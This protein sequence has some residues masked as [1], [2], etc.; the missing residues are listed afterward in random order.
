MSGVLYNPLNGRLTAGSGSVPCG[1]SARS[2]S[3]A[4]SYE[5][6]KPEDGSNHWSCT[7]NNRNNARNVNFN[8]GNAN[9]NNKYNGNVVRAVA[10]LRGYDVPEDFIASVWE[11]YHDCIRG[12]RR[13]EQAVEYM[14]VAAEDIPRL[15]E[16]LWSGTYKPG[17]STCF[18]V[19]YP[20]LREVFAAHFRDRIV[21]HWICLRLEPLFEDR[22]ISQGNVSF[23]CRKGFGTDKAVE[24]VAEGMRTVSDNYHT[25]AWVFKGDLVG[26]F[27]S[28][29]KDRLW[30]RLERFILR[31]QKK[32][33]RGLMSRISPYH[34]DTMYYPI[35]LR[36]AK[37]VVM[38]RPERDCVLNSPPEWWLN[39]APNKS[40]FTMDTGMP[41]GNLTTQLFANFYMSFFVAYV[42]WLFRH[43][44]YCFAQFVD[45]F[46]IICDDQRF[47]INAIPKIEAFLRDVLGLTLH[48]EKRYF[49]PVSHGVLFVGAFIKPGRLYLSNRTVGRMKERCH[50]FQKMLV[51]GEYDESNLQH[52][53]CTLNS[54]LGFCRRRQTYNLRR[55]V[56][57]EDLFKHFYVKGHYETVRLKRPF[58]LTE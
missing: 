13:S 58:R 30:Q 36:T 54:Y 40:L 14:Q 27:M 15:A 34:G 26:F 35:L 12:K 42:R 5:A 44:R 32:D 17:T 48:K 51:S 33:G 43:H 19:R 53:E 7:E 52:M 57:P 29:D 37:A 8:N 10:A 31:W 16:E 20:K 47:L 9:N 50:A 49:Q 6:A 3:P 46:I 1:S 25:P 18:L 55:S 21:H 41:I 22:F 39:L 56:L 11:A 45:D 28:I 2:F 4:F 24:Y 23:N 38:H